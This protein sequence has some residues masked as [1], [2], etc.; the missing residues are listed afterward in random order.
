MCSAFISALFYVSVCVD[1]KYSAVPDFDFIVLIV[2]VFFYSSFY[3]SKD[4]LHTSGVINTLHMLPPYGPVRV[5]RK[6]YESL[7]VGLKYLI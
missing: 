7:Q 4:R 5:A 6:I 3:S 2:V 1:T